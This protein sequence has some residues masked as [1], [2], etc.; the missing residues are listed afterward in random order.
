MSNII[1]YCFDLDGTICNTIDKQYANATP[2]LEVV[3]KINELYDSG[4]KI[5]IFTARG[6]TSKIDYHDIT[7]SQLTTWNVK[8][9][10]LIDKNKPHFDILIDDK[11]INAKT[12][13][14][15]NNIFIDNEVNNH[16][17]KYLNEVKVIAD[18]IDEIELSRFISYI[19]KC[20]LVS[21]RIFV[22]G[23]GGSAANASHAVNDFRKICNI[24][25]YSVS[26]N[27]SEL[28]ARINDVGWNTCYSE[29]LKTSKLSPHDLLLVFSVGGGSDTTSQN[30]VEAMNFAKKSKSTILSV[31]SRDGGYAKK[32]S[33]SCI[34]IP[35]IDDTRITPHAEE[36][37]GIILHLVV[38]YL[39]YEY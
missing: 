35:I 28:T 24:E 39:S 38:N 6:G 13:R 37:Q 30:L 31:V 12:W 34:L 22:I 15:Q 1:T 16:I 7:M 10:E 36:W 29:W 26:E 8:F 2:Y 21:G 20:K 4:N 33:D 23:V 11:A 32:L 14:E 9:H 27:V 18:L 19:K 3:K 17:R 25:T 5:T